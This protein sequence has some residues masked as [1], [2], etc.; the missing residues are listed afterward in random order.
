MN[1]S[2]TCSGK[3]IVREPREKKK[4]AEERSKQRD[5]TLKY[6]YAEKKRQIRWAKYCLHLNDFHWRNIANKLI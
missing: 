1:A 4:E 2:N 6:K 3:W 5:P